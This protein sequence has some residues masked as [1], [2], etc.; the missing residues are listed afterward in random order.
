MY[1]DNKRVGETYFMSPSVVGDGEEA[2]RKFSQKAQTLSMSVAPVHMKT[3]TTCVLRPFLP[4]S[5]RMTL[6]NTTTITYYHSNT[7][8]IIVIYQTLK[9][10]L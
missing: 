7:F 4:R 3:Q 2:F 5:L 1:P 9:Y 8:I 10:F 6:R